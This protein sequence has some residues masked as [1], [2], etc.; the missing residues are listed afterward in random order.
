MNET[1][2]VVTYRH[3]GSDRIY[4]FVKGCD[5]RL[6]VNFWNGVDRWLW[7]YQGIPAPEVRLEDAAS[8]ITSWQFHGFEQQHLHVFVRTLDGR[9]AEQIWNP[10]NAHP[11]G[12]GWHWQDH[13]V[14]AAGVVAVDAP[15]A[16]AYRR[17]STGSLHDVYD[18]I[19]VF[20][21]GN[22]G[23]L[24]R[25]GW[26]ARRGTWQW[27]NHGR[28]ALGTDVRSRSGS[29]TYRHQGVK[30][31]YLFVEGSDGRLWAN[32]SDSTE[33][34]TAW[35]WANLGRPPNI[36]VRGRPQAVTH[37]HDGR[38]RIYVF[39][40]GSDDHL[41]TCYWNGID[42]WE[43]ADL[44]HPG[45]TIAVVGDAAA[46]PYAWD[47]TDRMYVFVRGSDGHLHTCYWNGID[48][49][50]W[51]DLGTPAPFGVTVTS[52]PGVV[53]F[54]WDGT[55]RLYI[56]IWGSDDHLHLCYWNGVDQW[57]WR[58]QGAPPAT[59]AIA[60]VEQTQAIQ[61]FRPGLSPCL[62]RPG[63]SGRCPDNDIALVAGKA[64]VLRVYPDTCQGTEGTVNRVSGL[65]EIR[66][67]GTAAWE[68]LTPIN[69][70]ITAR[71]SAAIDRGQTDHTLNFRIPA[72]RCRGELAI[73]VTPFDADHPGDVRSV[74]LLR[75]LRFGL[76]P[77]LQIRL[78]RI[79]YQNAARNMNVPA[80]TMADFM[81]TVQFLLRTYPIPDVQVVGDS[82][83]LYDGDFTNL[84][85][86]MNPLGARGTTGPI[87]SIIDRIKM[88]E[89]A[90]LGSRVKYFALY[91]GAP[92]NQTALGWGIWP[93]RAAGE[94]NQG[95]VMAQEI[96]HTCGRG[97][98]PCSVPDPDP[99]YPNYDMST[100]ASIG[101]YGFDIVT[102]DVK[103]PATYRDFM[104][105]CTP[106]WVSPYT[107]EA[108]A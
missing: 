84:F 61:F 90:S 35:H 31:I 93:D 28:P 14:P 1:P 24:Y 37:V 91:P 81:N 73:R 40:R 59:V 99:N 98:A 52:S 74:P 47:G 70:P 42:R 82:E 30:R 6:Y 32:F 8:A 15:D 79:R 23:R 46:V 34:Q 58:D 36:L 53:P 55:G 33:V 71:R 19:D 26:D 41:H 54:S 106:S 69:G 9:L 62:D 76:V 27:Q 108:L 103:D 38:E 60:G 95:W 88:A 100:P 17:Q 102:S 11:L 94:V 63:T 20:V 65:L 77:R 45:P 87:F 57:L 78:I 85:D 29:I 107:Y 7:A 39:V 22:D 68:S 48:R 12:A 56:F 72:N 66:P 3:E 25:N 75:T 89:M 83:E 64:T 5:D 13:G 101:E 10:T 43:W 44:G 51:A 49:W 50:L 80:P 92:A 104:S 97:H 96:G 2:A 16:I 18:R 86:D 105:Y 4:T 21:H 67:A